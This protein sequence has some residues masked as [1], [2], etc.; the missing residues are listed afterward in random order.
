MRALEGRTVKARVKIT[1]ARMERLLTGKTLQFKLP[2][3]ADEVEVVLDE[4]ADAMAKFDKIF[5][6]IWNKVLDSV[7]KATSAI[8]K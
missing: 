2:A 8:L 3:P 1:P 6:K 7:D 5:N 4:S